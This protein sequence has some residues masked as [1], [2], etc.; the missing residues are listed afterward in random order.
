MAILD[1]ETHLAYHVAEETLH[2]SSFNS[3]FSVLFL[4]FQQRYPAMHEKKTVTLK[5]PLKNETWVYSIKNLFTSL[6]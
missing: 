6:C 3:V 1:E 2:T 4:Y 5:V